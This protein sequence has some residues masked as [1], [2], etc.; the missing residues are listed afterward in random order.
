MHIK[1]A[2]LAVLFIVLSFLST[3][4]SPRD[5]QRHAIVIAHKGT[6]FSPDKPS[7]L[8]KDNFDY[9]IININQF[10]SPRSRAAPNI[11]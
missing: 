2:I 4:V 5:I 10:R 8:T 7:Y 9:Q 11:L 1:H 3:A 6:A